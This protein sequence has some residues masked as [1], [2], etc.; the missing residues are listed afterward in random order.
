THTYRPVGCL[1]CRNTGYM[2][3][4][5][6]YEILLL[7]PEIRRLI[8]AEADVALIRDQAY[9]E[10]MKPLRIS[11][12]YKVALGLTTIEEVL[13]VAPPPAQA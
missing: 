7:S 5:G 1:E 8:H 2:G 6:L 12:A 11:G 3:R 9:K 10:G 4:I 13:K